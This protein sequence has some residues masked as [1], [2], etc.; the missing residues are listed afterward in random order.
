[1]TD[2]QLREKI[3]EIFSDWCDGEKYGD[4][5]EEKEILNLCKQYALSKDKFYGKGEIEAEIT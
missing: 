5:D 2:K 1:M 3:E 4:K